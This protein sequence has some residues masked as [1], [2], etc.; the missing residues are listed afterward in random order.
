MAATKTIR[1]TLDLVRIKPS[2]TKALSNP[3]TAVG[4][5][6][7]PIGIANKVLQEILQ[8]PFAWKWN[9][10]VPLPFTTNNLQ[11][12]YST[13]ITD[14]GWLEDSERIEINNPQFAPPAPPVFITRGV[15]AVREL[16]PCSV[17][18]IASQICWLPNSEALCGAWIAGTVYTDP[19]LGTI[20]P[21][22]PF[23]QIRDSNGNIQV[24]TTFGT[25]GN[26][27]PTWATVANTQ[28]PDGTAVWTMADPN[29]I[30]WRISP[31]PPNAGTVYQ[32]QPYYQKKP[33]TIVNINNL[34]TVPDELSDV[35]E[36]GF[37]AYAWDAAEEE[38][39]FEKTYALFQLRIKKAIMS[40][41]HEPESFCMFPGRS[42]TGASG[43]Y[44]RGDEAYPP[45]LFSQY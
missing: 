41:D 23:T 33:T 19:S 14:L 8:E 20:M 6:A 4:G 32:I 31:L 26:T 3:V 37:T 10:R 7:V 28:T 38:D 17:Q 22:Q 12:D 29:G 2:L 44:T 34:W 5:N 39:K 30:T 43:S 13:S 11:Q 9:R 21:Q 27:P 24:L 18:G 1:Q 16:L 45:G 15:D 25:L 42:I 40:N 36:T 35:Y